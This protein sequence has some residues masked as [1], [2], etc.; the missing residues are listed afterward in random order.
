MTPSGSRRP[1]PPPR[2]PHLPPGRGRPRQPPSRAARRPAA[3]PP[4]PARSSPSSPGN[5]SPRP[6]GGTPRT[7]RPH[8]PPPVRLSPRSPY[9]S[10]AAADAG[11]SRGTRGRPGSERA[12]ATCPPGRQPPAAAPCRAALAVRAE[13]GAALAKAHRAER[14]G[15]GAVP[16]PA[17][18]DGRPAALGRGSRVPSGSGEE[19]TGHRPVCAARL[20]SPPS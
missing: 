4:S 6:A 14:P 8:R 20:A 15:S 11:G 13:D 17:G 16:Q 7:P 2:R 18:V 19:T 5:S 1:L 12:L 9:P 10:P 3:G